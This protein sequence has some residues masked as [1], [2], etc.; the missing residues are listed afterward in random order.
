[1]TWTIQ[2]SLMTERQ[3]GFTEGQVSVVCDRWN[4]EEAGKG[5]NSQKHRASS[6]QNTQQPQF[7]W[8]LNK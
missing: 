4:C 8:S 5:S 2:N 3:A 1:M 7:G 6:G